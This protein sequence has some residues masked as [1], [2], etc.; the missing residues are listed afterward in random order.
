MAKRIRKVSKRRTLKRGF[1]RKTYKRKTFKRKTYKRKTFKRKTYKR[2]TFKRNRMRLGGGPRPPSDMHSNLRILATPPPSEWQHDG[3]SRLEYLSKHGISI[4]DAAR[5]NM[6][7]SGK[8]FWDKDNP[9]LLHGYWDSVPIEEPSTDFYHR[10]IVDTQDDPDDHPDHPDDDQD[11][12]RGKNI[13][14]EI[15][16][17][18]RRMKKIKSTWFPKKAND[19][20]TEVNDLPRYIGPSGRVVMVRKEL[21]DKHKTLPRILK[22]WGHH[23]GLRWFTLHKGDKSTSEGVGIIRPNDPNAIGGVVPNSQYYTYKFVPWRTDGRADVYEIQICFIVSDDE[24]V[25]KFFKSFTNPPRL[26][27]KNDIVLYNNVLIA[28]S[29]RALIQTN[30]E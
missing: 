20:P 27:K 29:N 4:R 1:K 7:G 21:Q 16:S 14:S 13:L 19:S 24:V 17:K 9:S 30:I 11:D 2:K 5:V 12:P 15:K 8:Y 10:S 28:S 25:S 26:T 6:G 18:W 23:R 22:F 3:N